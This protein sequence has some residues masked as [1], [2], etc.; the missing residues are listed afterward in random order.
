MQCCSTNIKCQNVTS[1]FGDNS[2]ILIYEKLSLIYVTVIRDRLI[3]RLHLIFN[4]FHKIPF[5]DLEAYT[6]LMSLRKYF[7]NPILFLRQMGKVNHFLL[8]KLKICLIYY[9]ITLQF[10]CYYYMHLGYL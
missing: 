3:Y 5:L 1:Y 10:I 7:A 4:L 6:F 9:A 2:Y 8:S